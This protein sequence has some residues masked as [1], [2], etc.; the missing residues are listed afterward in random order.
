MTRLAFP[1]FVRD[2]RAGMNPP[3]ALFFM[4]FALRASALFADEP[5]RFDFGTGKVPPGFQRVLPATVF[6]AQS[7]YGFEPGAAIVSDDGSDFCESEKPFFFSAV[8]P[9]GNYRVTFTPGHGA[10]DS[11]TTIKA[12]LRRLMVENTAEARSFIVNVRTPRIADGVSV[13]LKDREK[14][15]EVWNWDD[16]LTLE[17]NGKHPSVARIEIARV[18]VP[19]LFL[20]GDSTVCDQPHEP[21]ASWGQ[22]LTR[23]FKPEIAVANHAESGESLRSSFHAKRLEKVAGTL[24]PGDTVLIQFGHN[25]EKERGEGIGAFTTYKASLKQYVAAVRAR[26]GE[27]VL[28]TPVQ[29]RTFEPDGK[30]RN[31]HG[32]YPEAVKQAAAEEAVPLIDLH[33]LSA[34]LYEALGPE[35]SG[36][37]FKPGD[38]T[39]HNNYGAYELARCVV[40]GIRAAKLPLAKFLA[41]DLPPFDPV[42]PDALE[43]FNIPASPQTTDVTPLGN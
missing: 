28:V 1:K 39:H 7:G 11:A 32:D 26:G 17:F 31:S 10:G 22:M 20:L 25:D 35:K 8:L 42:H 21:F 18:E 37:L 5:L 19:V 14:T 27:P 29:R 38:G 30:I 23:F 6:S 2:T 4:A 36:V 24:K 15:A 13:H 43:S 41:D 9:E 33:A 34:T 16:K 40:E 12:E 3:R